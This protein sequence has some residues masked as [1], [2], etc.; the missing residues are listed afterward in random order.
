MRR[1][2]T[3]T[4]I[5]LTDIDLTP[6][7][8]IYITYAQKRGRDAPKC[9]CLR[10]DPDVMVVL[11][12]TLPDITVEEDKI[13][14]RL[15]QEETLRFDDSDDV[16]IQIAAKFDDDSVI[17]SEIIYTGVQCILKDGVI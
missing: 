8:A 1:G 9:G 10:D 16:L 15:T 17:R 3:P 6:A 5:F 7:E 2:T 4:H 14:T 12:K 11:E 13:T